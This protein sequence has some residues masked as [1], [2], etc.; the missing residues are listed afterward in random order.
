[1]TRV[2]LSRQTLATLAAGAMLLCGPAALVATMCGLDSVLPLSPILRAVIIIV[3][4]PPAVVAMG[5]V[6]LAAMTWDRRH[7]YER[8]AGLCV[9]CGY[10]LRA[11]P[12]RC[13]ECGKV[14][15]RRRSELS[16]SVSGEPCCDIR[17][18][19]RFGAVSEPW[20]AWS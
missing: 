6:T 18:S 10:D 7:D 13:P 17:V 15:A 5:G 19:V 1:M 20:A 12:Y 16:P 11:T 4:M 9:G 2:L 3:S 8:A 14:V